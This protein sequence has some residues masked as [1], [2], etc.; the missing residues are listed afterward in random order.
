MDTHKIGVLEFLDKDEVGCGDVV[1]CL[2]NS[3]KDGF[4]VDFLHAHHLE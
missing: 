2:S 4:D 1:A 3:Y